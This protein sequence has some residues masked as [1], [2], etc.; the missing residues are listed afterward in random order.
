MKQLR[1][2][3]NDLDK[4]P[5]QKYSMIA[6][7]Y[8][9]NDITYNIRNIY[10]KAEKKCCLD[11]ELP[12]TTLYDDNYYDEDIPAISSFILRDFYINAQ[13]KNEEFWKNDY[14]KQNGY[15]YVYKPG[16]RVIY[17]N[18]VIIE[19]DLV[20]IK[21]DIRLPVSATA[22]SGSLNSL[23]TKNASKELNKRKSNVI[24][25]K[26]LGIL[27]LKNL[28]ELVSCFINNFSDDNLLKAV[29]L[30]RNQEYIRK[31]IKSNGLVSFIGNGAILPRQGT[32][33]YKNS[34]KAIA[35][36]SPK[37]FEITINLPD[38]T[39]ISGMGIKE[40]ITVILGDAF[41]G[42]STL[43]T[44]IHEGIY[45][46][47]EGDGRE[48]VITVNS[49]VF[50]NSESGRGVQKTNISYY[51]KNIHEFD[52]SEFT[53]ISASGSTSQA[54][55]VT[56]AVEM[57]CELM[58]FDEDNCANNFMYRDKR[59]GKIF[60]NS[61][62]TPFI[63]NAH[64]FYKKFDISSIFAVGASFEY[65]DIADRVIFIRDYVVY[66]FKDYENIPGNDR[67]IELSRRN[68]D[69]SYLSR[70]DVLNSVSVQN[71]TK[72]ILG[73]DNVEINDIIPN[74][75]AGQINFIANIIKM[76]ITYYAANGKK[77][78]E[79]VKLCYAENVKPYKI[80]YNIS[81]SEVF[82]YVR[83]YDIERVLYRCRNIRFYVKKA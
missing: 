8:V 48:Y 54:A 53:T 75:S 65:L 62:T 41:Q 58:L 25:S 68:M 39:S 82:E 30:Y 74:V 35:F 37:S 80:L 45:N 4:Q 50:I 19:G 83:E 40:G 42:K 33:D 6:G 55:A 57:G 52:S 63:D 3:I 60:L 27:L 66:E 73:S 78:S 56:E 47:V 61:P 67:V 76:L 72:L 31:Y 16:Q 69:W 23:S 22:I 12:K 77:L 14:N 43:L 46:H 44:A 24:S 70:T 81:S 7:R 11:I 28:P 21:L 36:K 79:A 1:K 13:I 15:F 51:L 34:R 26:S 29:L 20:H 10:G 49:A 59:L 9:D 18:V 5:I 38:Y 71:N 17:N 64:T 2:I 32:S